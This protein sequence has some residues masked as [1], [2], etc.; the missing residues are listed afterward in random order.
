LLLLVV[1]T[2]SLYARARVKLPSCPS[3]SDPGGPGCWVTTGG[4]MPPR[5]DAVVEVAG[6]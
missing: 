1:A 3:K 2:P 6:L 4:L 5:P